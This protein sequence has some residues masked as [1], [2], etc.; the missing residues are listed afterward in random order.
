MNREDLHLTLAHMFHGAGIPTCTPSP[1]V[2]QYSST[3]LRIWLELSGAEPH[4]RRNR[5]ECHQRLSALLRLAGLSLGPGTAREG[6]ILRRW[7]SVGDARGWLG[8]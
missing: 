2:D 8:K 1:S 6:R 3:M 4:L 5:A 7:S